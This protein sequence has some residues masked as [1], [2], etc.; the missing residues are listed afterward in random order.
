M[1]PTTW[2]WDRDGSY[3]L[4]VVCGLGIGVQHGKEISAL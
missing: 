2:T 1:R 3:Y 4:S